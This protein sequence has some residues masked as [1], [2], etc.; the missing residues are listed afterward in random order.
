[1]PLTK[2]GFKKVFLRSSREVKQDLTD[3]SALIDEVDALGGEAGRFGPLLDKLQRDFDKVDSETED[4]KGAYKHA[5]KNLKAIKG[6]LEIALKGIKSQK[7]FQ[8]TDIDDDDLPP[9]HFY[10]GS[11]PGLEKM[12]PEEQA[13]VKE[14][15]VEKIKRGKAL[16]DTILGEDFDPRLAPRPSRKDLAD[17]A[18]YIKSLA[19]TKLNEPSAKGAINLPDPG[20]KIRKYMERTK[21]MYYR[22]S[23]HL[24]EQSNR[25][26]GN[27]DG[28]RTGR[29]V[30]FYDGSAESLDT[31]LPYGMHTV[32]MQSVKTSSGEKLFF[33]MET[34]SAK[35]SEHLPNKGLGGAIL[36]PGTQDQ[37]SRWTHPADIGR[38]ILHGKNLFLPEKD[39]TGLSAFREQTPSDDVEAFDDLIADLRDFEDEDVVAIMTQGYK[40]KPTSEKKLAKEKKKG[41]NRIRIFQMVKNAR[42]ALK[43]DDLAED[44]K[45]RIE[46]MLEELLEKYPDADDRFGGEM[47]LG[48]DDLGIPVA[49]DDSS[50]ETAEES[51][52]EVTDEQILGLVDEVLA[53]VNEKNIP[54]SSTQGVD[55]SALDANKKMAREVADEFLAGNASSGELIA[56]LEDLQ[57]LTDDRTK[58]IIQGLIIQLDS[59]LV[60]MD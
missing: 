40:D 14:E 27:P 41:S 26:S 29:G 25:K 7:E 30:D 54:T 50:G 52:E 36:G 17:F 57:E 56:A 3:L 32:L 28:S 34:Q 37:S 5:C 43:M 21:G 13:E 20:N 19:E 45:E 1:M 46:G 8:K 6:Q 16:C 51:S 38:S 15:I 48:G 42:Q 53:A 10:S 39:K 33:K 58:K 24:E 4:S 18:W 9:L 35:L 49:E 23:S 60:K 22:S 47:V 12:S 31:L 11:V 59:L 2:S 55:T 44:I